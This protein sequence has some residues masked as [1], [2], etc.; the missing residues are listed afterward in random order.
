MASSA[1]ILSGEQIRAARALARIDQLALA[2]LCG[3]SLETIKRLERIRGP[4]EANVRTLAAIVS[5]FD[6]LGVR[7]E[8]LPEGRVGV[9]LAPTPSPRPAA[10]SNALL[11]LIFFSTAAPRAGRS[12]RE[13]LDHIQRKA[14]ANNATLGVTGALFACDDRYLEAL[15][16]PKEAVLRIYGAIS[17]DPSHGAISLIENRAS[18]SR[19]FHDW[20]LCCGRFD[21]E[22]HIFG[23]EPALEKGFHPERLTPA[24]ALGLLSTVR[25]LEDA[26]PRC[27]RRDRSQCVL[28][29]DC[30]DR[31]CAAATPAPAT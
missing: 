21:G 4:V 26:D 2:R 25:E 12:R 22:D 30:R 6:E 8:K 28:M 27:G 5:A 3:L 9:S 14:A 20:R 11:R 17:S 15:E 1:L 13:L 19:R 31:S 10:A 23:A 18:T 7:F 29:G 24:A 16:G